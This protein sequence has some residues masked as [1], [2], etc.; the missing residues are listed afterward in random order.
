MS[1]NKKGIIPLK[2]LG[3]AV[4]LFFLVA[5]VA[6]A[7]FSLR[8]SMENNHEMDQ[9]KIEN[10]PEEERGDD[11]KIENKEVIEEDTDSENSI[12]EI[13][14][15]TV[16][17]GEVRS[18]GSESARLTGELVDTG[19]D[20]KVEV[21]FHYG[22]DED[23]LYVNTDWLPQ[24]STGEFSYKIE[25]LAFNTAYYFKAEAKNSKGGDYGEVYFFNTD[26]P[27][28]ASRSDSLVEIIEFSI[29][30]GELV[31]LEDNEE[32]TFLLQKDAEV[33]INPTTERMES[34]E[35]FRAENE[36]GD[37][38]VIPDEIF[39]EHRLRDAELSDIKTGDEAKLEL[40]EVNGDF[41]IKRIIL[42]R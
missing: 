24:T 3:L 34:I 8:E 37:C 38:T 31:V 32:K 23:N 16:K 11:E 17:T 36:E 14:L 30:D 28:G 19:G 39:E 40:H 13:D 5:F 12:K 6:V 9:K 20:E 1:L 2:V 15:P 29:E 21:R 22:E 26:I 4:L 27:T 7:Y 33:L 10:E 35:E 18:V 25:S 42:E 41:F